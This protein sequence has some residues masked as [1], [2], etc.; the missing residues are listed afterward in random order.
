MWLRQSQGSHLQLIQMG[1]TSESGNSLS[2]LCVCVCLAG[3]G[4]GSCHTWCLQNS[5]SPDWAHVEN[6]T[7]GPC[8][9]GQDFSCNLNNS[10]LVFLPMV[11]SKL[12]I[13][14]SD[15]LSKALS[16]RGILLS[17]FL[18]VQTLKHVAKFVGSV[19]SLD[20]P[21][22]IPETRGKLLNSVSE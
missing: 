20:C 12:L 21:A 2:L 10:S 16:S 5:P 17:L 14:G 1:L 6:P 8:M 9:K 13:V 3:A 15:V 4:Q 7:Y 19:W 11:C 18:R 22:I